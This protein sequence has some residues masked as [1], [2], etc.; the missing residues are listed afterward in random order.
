MYDNSINFQED[1]CDCDFFECIELDAALPG[2]PLVVEVMDKDDWSSDDLIG[3]TVIDLED[4]WFDATWQ[5]LGKHALCDTPGQVRWNA[6]PVELRPL[7]IP[8]QMQP[9]GHLEL[10]VDI[11]EPGAALTYPPDDIALPPNKP[12]QVRVIIWQAKDVND[13]DITGMSDTYVKVRG[14]QKLI[15]NHFPFRRWPSVVF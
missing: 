8:A 15:F 11:L 13:K 1:L 6:K 9:Q 14:A 12:F 4:R 5:Q 2:P 10:W 3:R 7:R